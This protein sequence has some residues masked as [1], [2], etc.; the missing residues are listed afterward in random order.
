[1]K[2]P[3]E[4]YEEAVRRLGEKYTSDSERVAKAHK[5]AVKQLQDAEEAAFVRQYNALKAELDAEAEA[6]VR[7]IGKKAKVAG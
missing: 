7:R 4:E 1:M 6:R 2:S 3:R 5:D